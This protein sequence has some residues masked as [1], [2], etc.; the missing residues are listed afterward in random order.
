MTSPSSLKHTLAN[1]ASSATKPQG[2]PAPSQSC[3]HTSLLRASLPLLYLSLT[4]TLVACGG[5][6]SSP[7]PVPPPPPPPPPPVAANP[8]NG[9]T[10]WNQA[11]GSNGGKCANCH[12]AT[13][14]ANISKIWN[15]SGTAA[16]QGNPSAIADGINRSSTGMSE[17]S[18][19]SG[20]KLTDIAAYI[21]AVRYN[22][23]I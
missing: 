8:K 16:D 5:G 6:S 1:S 18:V 4:A 20:D 12:G 11:L 19:V 10:L 13:P 15:A 3:S 2:A 7:A 22:K 9:Q 14:S 17:F 23:P 21:N